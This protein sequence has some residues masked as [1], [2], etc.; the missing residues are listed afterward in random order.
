MPQH[1][2][3]L[4][5]VKDVQALNVDADDLAEHLLAEYAHSELVRRR[6]AELESRAL[7]AESGSLT[8]LASAAVQSAQGVS[9]TTSDAF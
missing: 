5:I 7:G 4:G 3:L 9:V 6:I 1:A 8:V 2:L